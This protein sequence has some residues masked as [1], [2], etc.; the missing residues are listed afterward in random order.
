MNKAL[1]GGK[2]LP[3]EIWELVAPLIPPPKKRRLRY[4]GRHRLDDRKV[5]TLTTTKLF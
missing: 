1:S 4:P 3:D 2:W 5:W